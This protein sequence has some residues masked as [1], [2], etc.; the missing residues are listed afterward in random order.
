MRPV[1]RASEAQHEL[2]LGR[3]QVCVGQPGH[4]E[5]GGGVAVRIADDLTGQLSIEEAGY[6]FPVRVGR[7]R[8]DPRASVALEI[9]AQRQKLWKLR[10]A[11]GT[12]GRPEMEEDGP[13]AISGKALARA[14]RAEQFEIR[15]R[16]RRKAFVGEREC[17]RLGAALPVDRAIARTASTCAAK[18][19]NASAAIALQVSCSMSP[20]VG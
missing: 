12:P 1:A 19:A 4:F 16:A 20:A 6:R 14:V 18:I 5:R 17:I 7:H 13:A 2:T 3:H 9:A 11:R 10:L 8:D 15:R